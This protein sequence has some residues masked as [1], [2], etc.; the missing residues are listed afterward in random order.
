MSKQLILIDTALSKA[1]FQ[2]ECDLA[3]G[4]LP[5]L[6]NLENYLAA[7]SGGNQSAVIDC[8][9]GAIQAT[10][11]VTSTG[12]ATA[13]QTMKL[14]NQT[15]EAVASGADPAAGEFNVSATPA[16]QAE[17]IALAINSLPALSGLV[18]AEA[19]LGVVTITAVVPGIAGNAFECA[20]VDLANVTVAGF[21][22]GSNGT[23]TR[24][25]FL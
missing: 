5:A 20:D 1:G 24:L 21:S 15:I 2:S 18:T 7:I 16:T 14:C 8:N 10:A 19:N 9:V 13:A 22:G 17:S 11:S 23:V 12:A 25:N 4:Q 3:P 6:Q